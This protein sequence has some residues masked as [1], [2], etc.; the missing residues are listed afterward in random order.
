MGLLSL[1]TPLTWEQIRAIR[2]KLKDHGIVQFL[3]SINRVQNRSADNL[4]WGDEIEY[5]IVRFDDENK[6]VR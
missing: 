2:D 3:H 4:K 1:G 5:I 6:K